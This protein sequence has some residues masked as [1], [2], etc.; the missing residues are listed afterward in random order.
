MLHSFTG[1][2]TKE[3]RSWICLNTL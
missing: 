2:F 1:N 3:K